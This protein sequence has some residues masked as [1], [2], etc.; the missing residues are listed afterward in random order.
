MFLGDAWFFKYSKTA[1]KPSGSDT[2]I[3][4]VP[5]FY[6]FQNMGVLS[7]N[8]SG[9]ITCPAYR[10]HM[11]D[12]ASFTDGSSECWAYASR[13]SPAGLTIPFAQEPALLSGAAVAVAAG[14]PDD[15][16]Y[17]GLRRSG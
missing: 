7:S 15:A 2:G 8:A 9:A 10:R 12:T 16:V 1:S 17:C 13:S 11:L 14:N 4:Y 5:R 3:P 6:G